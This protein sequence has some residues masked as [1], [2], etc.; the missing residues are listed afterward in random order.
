V[1]SRRCCGVLPV[2]VS[3]SPVQVGVVGQP[4]VDRS[5]PSFPRVLG[6]AAHRRRRRRVCDLDGVAKA[7]VVAVD[8]DD[9]SLGDD[10]EVRERP[11]RP[12]PIRVLDG[13]DQLVRR[14]TVRIRP[15]ELVTEVVGR[16]VGDDPQ[17]SP[18]G[19]GPCG[20]G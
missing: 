18:G 4:V 16:R 2:S 1:R 14:E 15:G 3:G 7:V 9:D 10:V 6:G 12:H 5:G 17:A 19:A 11:A 8:H 13:A 20:G